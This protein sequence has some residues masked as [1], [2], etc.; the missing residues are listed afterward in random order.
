MGLYQT[1]ST[2]NL[3]WTW[4]GRSLRTRKRMSQ[5]WLRSS[6]TSYQGTA[7]PMRSHEAVKPRPDFALLFSCL[8]FPLAGPIWE[9]G[10]VGIRWHNTN[11]YMAISR[12]NKGKRRAGGLHR[13]YADLPP[14]SEN[15]SNSNISVTHPMQF[16]I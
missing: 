5:R 13:K 3:K 2:L 8:G 15:N 6:V 11:G 1:D 12:V 4:G 7:S 16:Y 10:T 14:I 9:T